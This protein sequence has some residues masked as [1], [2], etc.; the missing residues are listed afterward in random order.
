M[1]QI[2]FNRSLL[3]S[4]LA[5]MVLLDSAA[6]LAQPMTQGSTA[7]NVPLNTVQAHQPP[8]NAMVK[9]LSEYS[10][11]WLAAFTNW[12]AAHQ[13]ASDFNAQGRMQYAAMLE[14]AG[15]DLEQ[16]GMDKRYFVDGE[17]REK[18]VEALEKALKQGPLMADQEKERELLNLYTGLA[19]GITLWDADHKR[20]AEERNLIE[21]MK[22]EPGMRVV[23]Q[24]FK[25]QHPDLDEKEA[26]KQ[27]IEQERIK[28]EQ[29]SVALSL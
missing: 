4:V 17:W 21:R 7:N 2:N 6:T 15:R 1:H 25:T 20:L 29:T 18:R 13:N 27:F 8:T 22:S 3:V 9:A 26:L 12:D 28:K 11:Q 16:L 14:Y 10:D 19:Y 24:S 5:G 23:L